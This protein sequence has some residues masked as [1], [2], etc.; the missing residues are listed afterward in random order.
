VPTQKYD[1]QKLEELYNSLDT[2]LYKYKLYKNIKS[3][4]SV[5]HKKYEEGDTIDYLPLTDLKGKSVDFN[6]LL[7]KK[8]IYIINWASGCFACAPNNE[9]LKM[10]Y[11][12]LKNKLTII[13]LS[14]DSNKSSLLNTIKDEKLTWKNY[15]DF[16]GMLSIP[17]MLLN[18]QFTPNGTLVAPNGKI[19]KKD[20]HGI[21]DVDV[22]VKEINALIK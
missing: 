7:G 12:K 9:K 4:I 13:G 16:K 8:Y 1:R 10:A 21:K 6:T 14:D 19:I 18:S 3:A 11:K 5:K 20:I 22:F 15:C 17:S 2:S